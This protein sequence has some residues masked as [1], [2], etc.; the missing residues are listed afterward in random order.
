[1]GDPVRIRA[2]GEED[3]SEV[4]RL[5]RRVFPDAPPWN[6]PSR[7][8]ELKLSVQRDLFLVATRH[9]EVVGT[10]MAGFDGHR[11]WIY[12]LAV[13]PDLGGR[14]LGR[15]LMGEAER[16]LGRYGCT[17]VNLMV[18]GSNAAVVEF[19]RAIGYESEDRI[20]MSRR[21]DGATS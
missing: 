13:D 15:A 14:G 20:C 19:Y 11:G 5:W 9:E 6:V 10:V 17:K 16:R 3:E 18:R 21:L 7:D 12:Y 8:I 2:Y 1:M 4:T